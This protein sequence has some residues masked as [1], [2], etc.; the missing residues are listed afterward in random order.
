MQSSRR[1]QAWRGD[2]SE[3]RDCDSFWE[4]CQETLVIFKKKKDSGSQPPLLSVLPLSVS[5]C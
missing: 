5:E 3:A 1:A 2:D 4:I